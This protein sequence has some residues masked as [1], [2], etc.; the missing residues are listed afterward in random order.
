MKWELALTIALVASIG[1]YAVIFD[2]SGS[3]SPDNIR[4]IML[5]LGPAGPLLYTALIAIGIVVVPIP[6][7]PFVL[8]AGFIYGP[9][10]ALA[11]TVVGYTIGS[12]AAFLIG[13]KLGR[14]RVKRKLAKLD[15]MQILDKFDGTK[16]FAA[17]LVLRLVPLF[18]FDIV[19]YAA[20]L[21][22][23][24][25]GKFAL[26]SALGSVPV[27]AAYVFLGSAA[28]EF[29]LAFLGAIFLAM[30]A[31]VTLAF[32]YR[33][34]V[35]KVTGIDLDRLVEKAAKAGGGKKA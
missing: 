9:L 5:G 31:L 13:R 26:A 25:L 28:F 3:L 7:I 29:N 30:F 12:A 34:Q 18:S 27:T 1:L 20:G 21:T 33:K 8:V 23:I 6:S 4:E 2:S 16:G 15:T 17:I 32:A 24:R 19:S 22:N 11:F 14:E 35:A 10:A